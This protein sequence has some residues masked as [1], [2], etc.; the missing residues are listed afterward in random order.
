[1]RTALV[2]NPGSGSIDD[3]DEVVELLRRAG[4]EEVLRFDCGEEARA[5]AAGASRLVVAGGDGTIAPSALAAADA[6]L[7]LAVLAAG[8]ANDFARALGLPLDLEEAA[9]LAVRADARTRPVEVCVTA[10][11]RPFVN[12]A[13]AGLAVRAAREAHGL[14]A[15]LG[16]LAY[17]VGAVRAGL[18]APA[19]T[20]AVT[21]D[22]APFFTGEAWKVSVSG[23][24]RFGGGSAIGET[25]Q[26]D[27]LIDV[28]VVPARHRATL[29][30]H[31][32]GL[33]RGTLKEQ[34]DV[35]HERA[36]RVGVHIEADK[37]HRGFNV[38]GELLE[39][40][41]LDVQVHPRRAQVVVP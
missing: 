10:D 28:T 3:P 36:R 26:D 19:I 1:M 40:G 21:L 6:G 35:P 38:D 17:G 8:T 25:D 34:S 9:R 32:Y 18:R 20:V 30:R 2:L 22:G 4:A 13:N 15:R 11:G 27:G 41:D 12:A 14:K 23:T 33:R 24:G 29:I 7:P 5:V 31:A 16:P 39:V 37:D